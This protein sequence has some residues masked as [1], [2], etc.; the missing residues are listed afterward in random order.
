VTGW[1]RRSL[2]GLRE[3]V[4]GGSHLGD[5][6]QACAEQDERT[7]NGYRSALELSWSAEIEELLRTQLEG[8]DADHTR[9]KVLRG[10]A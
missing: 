3:T 8:I 1:V 2:F 10:E 5:S 9:M 6:F 4:L 7:A